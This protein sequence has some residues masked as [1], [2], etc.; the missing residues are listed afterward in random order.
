MVNGRNALV[1]VTRDFFGPA[2]GAFL[3]RRSIWDRCTNGLSQIRSKR[4][5]SQDSVH[6]G[7][8]P[9]GRLTCALTEACWSM[10]TSRVVP[11]IGCARPEP[12]EREARHAVSR[13]GGRGD[14]AV[15]CISSCPRDRRCGV[16]RRASRRRCNP[17]F[18]R[19]EAGGRAQSNPWPRQ[20]CPLLR[21]PGAGRSAASGH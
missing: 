16:I 18:R 21:R 2:P 6:K 9:S 11:A 10:S 14:A 3:R 17:L 13:A 8:C 19:R 4:G 12:C 15:R 1:I 20:H 5:Y 7:Y